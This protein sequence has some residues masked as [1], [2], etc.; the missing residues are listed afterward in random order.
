MTLKQIASWIT[1]KLRYKLATEELTLIIDMANKLSVDQDMDAFK[2]WD[3]TLTIY[4]EVTFASAGYTNCISTDVGKAVVG[5]ESGTT[6]LLVSYDNDEKT[7]VINTT[8]DFTAGEGLT[9]TT[10][11]G[12]GDLASE[13]HQEGYKGPYTFPTSPVCRKMI[14]I[15]TITDS[16]IFGTEAVYTSDLDDYG[17]PLGEYDERR[18]Y[19]NAR[20]DRFANTLTFISAPS[21]SDSTT[22]RW[23]YFRGVSDITDLDSHD[24]YLLIDP[25]FHIDFVL[26]C[27]KIAS[28]VAEDGEFDRNDVES[29]FFSWWDRLRKN[30][31]PMGKASNQTNEGNLEL[32]V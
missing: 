31:T 11:T 5:D 24:S 27:S 21:L 12:A 13:D 6:G 14:G 7:W 23:V 18:F 15:T 10:G 16:R 4:S 28:S 25:M 8:D 26:A 29:A 30:Y 1:R 17:I 9:I 19:V 2:Y 22:Y 20:I 32:D 3:N